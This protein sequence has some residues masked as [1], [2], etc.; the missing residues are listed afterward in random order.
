MTLKKN[1]KKTSLSYD[2]VKPGIGI[3]LGLFCVDI[4]RN[5]FLAAGFLW[6]MK[7]R[8]WAEEEHV[9]GVNGCISAE[10]CFKKKE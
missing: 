2:M 7:R 4:A 8:E 1:K 6:A 3:M 9:G 10:S 5:D